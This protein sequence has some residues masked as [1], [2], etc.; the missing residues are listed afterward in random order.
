MPQLAQ[1]I[2]QGPVQIMLKLLEKIPLLNLTGLGTVTL[3]W[4]KDL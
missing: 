3:Y 4:A 2:I 1:L